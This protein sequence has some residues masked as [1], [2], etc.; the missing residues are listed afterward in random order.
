MSV[1]YKPRLTRRSF[2]T[3]LAA[4]SAV[5]YTQG[6][7]FAKSAQR[8]IDTRISRRGK[9]RRVVILG[10][11]L[12]G[13]VAGYELMRAGH[14]VVI[15]EGR[16]RPG[17][18]VHTLRTPFSDGLFA[19]AGAGRIPRDHDW[20]RAY[21]RQFGLATEPFFPPSLVPVIYHRGRRIEMTPATPLARFFDLSERD[22]ALTPAA[23]AQK[24]LV[25]AIQEVL[26][27]GD[28]SSPSWPPAALRGFDPISFYDL[29]SK[30][31]ASPGVMDIL[32][33][34]AAPV[35][36]VSALWA[37]RILA[38][39]DFDHVDRIQGGNDLLPQAIAAKL[40][41]RI[42]YRA[43]VVSINDGTSAAGATY[44]KDG[45][46]HSL[47]ADYIICTLPFSILRELR[48]LPAWSPLKRRAIREMNYESVTRV[49][50]QMRERSWERHG[51][52]GFAKTDTLAEVWS[53]SWDQ[54]SPRGLL[55]LYQ[56]GQRARELDASVPL[57]R[58]R[59]GLALLQAI[60]PECSPEAARNCSYSWQLDG[61]ARGAYSLMA[62]GQYSTWYPAVATPEG[63]VHFAGEHTSATPGF[64]QGAITSGHRAAREVNER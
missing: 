64:M 38:A 59:K 4:A 54:A 32:F 18:R 26:A 37:L 22:R 6:A 15:L 28:L 20:T 16:T 2:L 63:R 39:T 45:T 29:F 9:A 58:M 23:M 51:L 3:A 60:F 42:H 7:L 13:L 56:D 49:T 11:G 40:A 35:K 62:P 5:S 47:S 41:G 46:H 34:G 48:S 57:V 24:Y 55:Q 31:G 30:Q 14:D 10:A 12:S 44:V 27:A 53:P 50:V 36:D 8:G 33:S 1:S 61:F 21:I 43:Q 25:P 17:G 19:E 52:S